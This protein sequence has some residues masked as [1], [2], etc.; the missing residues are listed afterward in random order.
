MINTDKLK[1]YFTEDGYMR[2]AIVP[3]NHVQSMRIQK[4]LIDKN[5]SWS[6]REWVSVNRIYAYTIN[7]DRPREEFYL[8]YD[9][10]KENYL[11]ECEWH[12]Y[13]TISWKELR[14]MFI[15]DTDIIIDKLIGEI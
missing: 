8:T 11:N 4:F 3:E 1:R 7:Y 10:N 15:T 6:G 12:N 9:E 2:V 5:I 14:G 13:K